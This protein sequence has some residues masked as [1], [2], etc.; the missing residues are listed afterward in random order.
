MKQS[1]QMSLIESLTN[2]AVGY[3]LACL[4]QIVVF[5]WFDLAVTAGQTLGIGLIF[6]VVSIARSYAIRRLF[7]RVRHAG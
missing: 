6:T 5:P 2:V 3:G 4:T 7:E 1:R